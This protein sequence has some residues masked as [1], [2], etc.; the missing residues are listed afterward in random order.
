LCQL[1][2]PRAYASANDISS[3]TSK[4]RQKTRDHLRFLPSSI[5]QVCEFKKGQWTVPFPRFRSQTP[6]QQNDD[7][8]SLDLCEGGWSG[9]AEDLLVADLGQ[10]MGQ[11]EAEVLGDELSEVGALDVLGLGQLD[12]TEDLW[13]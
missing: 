5:S 10:A 7:D 13:C 9:G 12:D 1:Y 6:Q 11:G 8:S 3:R 2:L 4:H